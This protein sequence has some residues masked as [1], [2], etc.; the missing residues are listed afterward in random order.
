MSLIVPRH[1][2]PKDRLRNNKHRLLWPSQAFLLTFSLFVFVV[3][4]FFTGGIYY[5]ISLS[6]VINVKGFC[7]LT[8]Y[9][10]IYFVKV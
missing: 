3:C 9:P 5:T 2:L 10:Y 1:L 4:R 8:L 7:N 6:L